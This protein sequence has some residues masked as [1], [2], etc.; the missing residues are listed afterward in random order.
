[1]PQNL[2]QRIS[3]ILKFRPYKFLVRVHPFYIMSHEQPGLVQ[4]G[5]M[6]LAFLN[7]PFFALQRGER[8]AIVMTT[9]SEFLRSRAASPLDLKCP[10]SCLARSMA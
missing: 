7:P 1:M 6:H 10:T 4:A 5:I 3:W 2:D 8:I 9:S